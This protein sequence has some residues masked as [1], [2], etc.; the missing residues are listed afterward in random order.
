MSMNSVSAQRVQIERVINRAGGI[1]NAQFRRT[2]G[3]FLCQA[4]IWPE[5]AYEDE[6]HQ[7]IVTRS[8]RLTPEEAGQLAIAIQMAIDWIFEESQP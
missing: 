6:P 3:F 5:G 7:Q 4:S 2:D 1:P 8:G